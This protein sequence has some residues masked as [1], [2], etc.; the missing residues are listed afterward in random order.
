MAVVV[1]VLEVVVDRK[2]FNTLITALRGANWRVV[3][4]PGIEISIRL[5]TV[6][7]IWDFFSSSINSTGVGCSELTR[8]SGDVTA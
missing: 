6:T 3:D 5:Q 1:V 8:S 2:H 4:D 7:T